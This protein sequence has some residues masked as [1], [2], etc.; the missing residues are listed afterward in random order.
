M[1]HERDC[2]RCGGNVRIVYGVLSCLQCGHQ[3]DGGREAPRVPRRSSAHIN[4]RSDA[5]MYDPELLAAQLTGW[6]VDSIEDVRRLESSPQVAFPGL[7]D[8]VAEVA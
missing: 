4:G 8:A 5:E 1:N 6:E 3:P 2:R 7:G